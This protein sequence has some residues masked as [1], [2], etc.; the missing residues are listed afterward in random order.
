MTAAAQVG[1]WAHRA[2]DRTYALMRDGLSALWLG[3]LTDDGLDRACMLEYNGHREFRNAEHGRSG[4]YPWERDFA[5]HYL[6]PGMRVLVSSAGGG[7]EVLALSRLGFAVS[8]FECNSRFVTWGNAFL[9]AEGVA[10]PIVQAPPGECPEGLPSCDAVIV[11][12]SSYHHILPAVRRVRFLCSL[13]RHVITGAPIL[14]SFFEQAGPRAL[15][16]SRW[17]N[18]IRRLLG[19]PALDPGDVFGPP[20]MHLFTRDEIHAELQQAG[21]GLDLYHNEGY[22]HAVGIAVA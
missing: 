20:P 5:D 14:V 3:F 16:P 4:L 12:W 10:V 9:Q 15:R 8:A 6:R 13:R 21:F 18:R 17:A 11:G 7:R 22:P 1:L 19:R 2:V